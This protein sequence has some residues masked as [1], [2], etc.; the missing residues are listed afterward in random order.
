VGMLENMERLK[1]R[2]LD[3]M[4]EQYLRIRDA[5][6]EHRFLRLNTGGRGNGVVPR[7]YK[8]QSHLQTLN[9]TIQRSFVGG[10]SIFRT[11]LQPLGNVFQWLCSGQENFS[12]PLKMSPCCNFNSQKYVKDGGH[13]GNRKD[14][15]HAFL[16]ATDL[17]AKD[18]PRWDSSP[19]TWIT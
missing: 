8:W 1:S 15:H 12:S 17:R 16:Q 2:E 19:C 3:G 4:F 13:P 7:I 10:T 9:T 18:F 6:S 5:I 14:G 11:Y